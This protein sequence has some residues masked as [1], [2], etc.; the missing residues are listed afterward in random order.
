MDATIREWIETLNRFLAEHGNYA[1]VSGH[2][3]VG[4]AS[5]VAAFRDYLTILDAFLPGI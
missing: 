5:D 2:G 1:F 4:T 3:A